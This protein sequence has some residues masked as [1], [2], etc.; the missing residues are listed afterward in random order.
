ML[1]RSWAVLLVL[2]S[3]A[4]QAG[5]YPIARE[6]ELGERFSL[7]AS[8]ALPLI[9]E[10][11]VLVFVD[12]VA[13]RIV[14]RLGSPQ[15][16]DYRFYVVRDAQLNAFAV[17]GGFV[18]LHSGLITRT[19]NDAELAGVLGHEIGHAHAHHIVRQQE[20][21]QLLTYGALAGVLL[22]VIQPALGAAALGASAAGQLKYQRDFEQEADYLGVRYMREAGFDPHGMASFMKRILEEQRNHPLEVPPYMLS[23]P[24]TDERITHLEAATRGDRESPGWTEPSW[25]LRRVQAILRALTEDRASVRAR[26]ARAPE[27]PQQLALLG[28][29]LLHQGDFGAALETLGRAKEKGVGGLEGDLGLARLRSGAVEEALVL[30]RAR[31]E[32]APEDVV[33]RASLGAALLQKGDLEAARNELRVV[34]EAAPWLDDAVFNLGQSYGRGGDKARGLFHLARAFELRG[35][36]ERA[37][38]QYEKAVEVLPAGSAEAEQ[39]KYKIEMLE[40]IT[41]QRV[42]G[43]RSR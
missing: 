18:Y 14:S 16:F 30:L 11:E 39:C 25:E 29:V 22:S 26:Y 20:K 35:D 33:A 13:Q 2:V 4:P 32:A 36:V 42:L 1:R 8:S 31:L 41:T 37:L 43:R 27:S 19:A 40:E 21:S 15:P 28:L 12:R 24:L 23:H 34:T 38:A 3:V 17:P 5:A 6:R 10:P 7:E 9:R